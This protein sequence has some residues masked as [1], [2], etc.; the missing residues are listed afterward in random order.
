M[1]IQ[2]LFLSSDLDSPRRVSM[3]AIFFKPF[4]NHI[5]KFMTIYASKPIS[6]NQTY[7]IWV[8]H[9]SDLTKP[10]LGLFGI[11]K[12]GRRAF[13]LQTPVALLVHL[14]LPVTVL[15]PQLAPRDV[16][17]EY[18]T[19][20]ANQPPKI[21]ITFSKFPIFPSFHNF[22][23]KVILWGLWRPLHASGD[24]I[25]NFGQIFIFI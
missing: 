23:T 25:C 19:N 13:F 18:A 2:M 24:L 22:D 4:G 6:L 16:T 11:Q 9:F 12:I 10:N 15:S 5:V 20:M 1:A 21:S 3:N 7:C 8:E 14:P 17:E